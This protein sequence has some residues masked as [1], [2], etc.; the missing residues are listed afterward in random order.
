MFDTH[1]DFQWQNGFI[2]P[3]EMD[4]P[5]NDEAGRFCPQ[6]NLPVKKEAVYCPH[7]GALINNRAPIISHHEDTGSERE[8]W[9]GVPFQPNEPEEPPQE[10]ELFCPS[11]SRPIKEDTIYCP[12]CGRLCAT[13][14]TEPKE[15]D[16]TDND[17][18]P[19]PGKSPRRSLLIIIAILAIGALIAAG[20]FLIIPLLSEEDSNEEKEGTA[21]FSQWSEEN[22][23]AAV[24]ATPW[25]TP[26]AEEYDAAAP[27]GTP[28][29]PTAA[30]ILTPGP[31][32][33]I[34]NG[35]YE[36][37]TVDQ[38]RALCVD[39]GGNGTIWLS[40]AA[41]GEGDSFSIF[42]GTEPQIYSI[43]GTAGSLGVSKSGEAL[44]LGLTNG[45]WSFASAGG[46]G[47][48]ICLADY[49][50][51]VL[52]YSGG[53]PAIE[54]YDPSSNMQKWSLTQS[55]T[56]QWEQ[57]TEAEQWLEAFIPML[58]DT[59]IT[60]EDVY[61]LDQVTMGYIRNGIYA[62]SGKIFETKAYQDF[63]SSQPWYVPYSQDGNAVQKRF[64]DYQ[65]HNLSICTEYERMMGWR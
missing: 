21:L 19:Q 11:C 15:W 63:F 47:Y 53:T 14:S 56:T 4:N 23:S 51:Y 24:T 57:G 13:A 16:N 9:M 64:N 60:A 3:D 29:L 46:G 39:A 52:G 5:H 62:L 41:K 45:R 48:Y 20:I 49:P 28:A 30:P 40:W 36:L 31:F 61:G 42:A 12:H 33:V 38:N 54:A 8:E 1:G 50:G 22:P 6:C 55:Q 37:C 35:Q 34:Q 65:N 7:C 26:Q 25:E 2:Q 17:P 32:T 10:E 44:Q 58:D 27:S 43:A 18:P 59:Y